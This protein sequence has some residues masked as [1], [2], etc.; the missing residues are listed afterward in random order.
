MAVK[1]T[2]E[3]GN[4]ANPSSA[5]Y[6]S[7]S[8]KDET[9]PGVSNDG[10]PLSSRVGNDFQGFMQ[11]ALAEAGIDANG[12]PDSVDNPQ[13]LNA[14]KK[15]Q[16]SHAAS[17][18]D[19]VYK[20]SG[21]N[22]AVENMISGI[23]VAININQ[24]CQCENGTIFKRIGNSSGTIDD[25]TS[26]SGIKAQDFGADPTG[27]KDSTQALRDAFSAGGNIYLGSSGVYSI[28][29][30]IRVP[31]NGNTTI[32]SDGAII[33]YDGAQT[34]DNVL[35][36]IHLT[37]VGTEIVETDIILDGNLSTTNFIPVGITVNG[38]M[39][40]KEHS[41]LYNMAAGSN[42]VN[43]KRFI[44]NDF[45][46][47]GM[48]QTTLASSFGGTYGYGV[49]LVN[50]DT[51]TIGDGIFGTATAPIERHSVYVSSRTD[52]SGSC[53]NVVVS[54]VVAEQIRYE[55]NGI[56]PITGFEAIFKSIDA[57]SLKVNNT[58]CYGGIS[59]IDANRRL[60]GLAGGYISFEGN[61]VRTSECSVRAF[62]ENSP[63]TMWTRFYGGDGN[64]FTLTKPFAR[65]MRLESVGTVIDHSTYTVVDTANPTYA[66]DTASVTATYPIGFLSI[67]GSY[68]GF[69]RLFTG[70]NVDLLTANCEFLNQ[71]GNLPPFTYGAGVTVREIVLRELNTDKNYYRQSAN[72][73]WEQIEYF[74]D[75]FQS[76][77]KCTSGAIPLWVDQQNQRVAGPLA[78]RPYPVQAGH[79]YWETDQNRFVYWTGS[80]WWT[81]DVRIPRSGT[82]AEILALSDNTLGDGQ[83]IYNTTTRLPYWYDDNANQWKDAA[84]NILS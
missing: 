23:P 27:A 52:G 58:T 41:T 43:V 10:T 1:L 21:G 45:F 32:F 48:K 60:N 77:I 33:R 59:F 2:D 69:S 54:N 62:T 49:V 82:T 76:T 71:S 42:P 57:R 84:G 22:S 75:D 83:K 36:L 31:L 64:N 4:R 63:T 8:L 67:K 9:N 38:A 37:G 70:G 61:N 34:V 12:N 51:G 35:T 7:G 74:E 29:D 46:Y 50:V 30:Q 17:Y 11:S 39:L 24:T 73:G 53:G 15:V 72:A 5:A 80:T 68:S 19:I 26:I 18:T 40:W 55:D 81:S 25:Y 3:F 44:M 16:E 79:K 13:I 6:P 14:L 78:N 56:S 47:Y 20:A 66:Y 65:A 28:T